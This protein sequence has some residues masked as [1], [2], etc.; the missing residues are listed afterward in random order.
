MNTIIQTPT[1]N[2]QSSLDFYAKL[3]FTTLSESPLLVSD[4]KAV[5]EINTD[6]FA[7]AGIKLFSDNWSDIVAELRLIT[8]VHAIK[9]GYLLSDASGVSIYLI[10]KTAPLSID[11]SKIPISVL[12]NYAGL[13]IETTDIERSMQ[14]Y[15]L[16]GFNHNMGSLEKG[17]IGLTN[18]DNVTVSL[19]QPNSCPHLFFNP[20]MT[21]FNGKKNL[22]IIEKIRNL[23]IPISEEITFFNKDN[24]VDNIIIRDPGGYGFF[25]FSD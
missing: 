10:E 24:I 22:K 13:S 21:F 16:L 23:N 19:M 7:R 1:N 4:G 11:L 2:L 9:E 25:L 15:A 20:S 5:I 3:S 18:N 14:V 6:R 8:K 12:G 17:W